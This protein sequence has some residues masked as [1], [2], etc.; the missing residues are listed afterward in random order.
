MI[1]KPDMAGGSLPME[2]CR[3]SVQV[4]ERV[5]FT[6]V[7]P[8]GHSGAHQGTGAAT[9]AL[10]EQVKDW[11]SLYE[12]GR[13]REQGYWDIINGFKTENARLTADQKR[14]ADDLRRHPNAPQPVWSGGRYQGIIIGGKETTE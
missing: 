3:E 4:D 7:L 14:L 13:Q 6:C 12:A 9:V 11:K 8:Q 5:G 10:R 1:S 2:Y